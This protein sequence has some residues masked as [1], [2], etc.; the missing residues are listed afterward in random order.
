MLAFLERHSNQKRKESNSGNVNLKF[1]DVALIKD[2][3]KSTLLWRK[4]KDSKFLDSYD[5]KICS[6]ELLCTKKRQEEH[7]QLIDPSSI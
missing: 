2:E 4:G 5:N 1:V 7:V 3:K 6:V